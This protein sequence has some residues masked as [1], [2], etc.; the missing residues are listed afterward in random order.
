MN[1]DELLDC[2]SERDEVVGT[3]W[4]SILYTKKSTC[5][6]VVNG[7]VIN[8]A[9]KLW[10]PR[11]SVQKKLFP[12]HLDASVGGHVMSGESYEQ[13]FIRETQEELGITLQ[14]GCYTTLGYLTPHDHGTSAFMWV[15]GIY[16][17]AIPEY[18]RE[19]FIDYYW[20]S[21]D[22]FFERLAQGDKS[23]SDLPPILR[24]LKHK[25]II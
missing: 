10:I 6:R 11:R 8:A 1:N 3:E 18:N 2:V 20:L 12:L 21:I 23:K 7:F 24:A 17:D 16:Q 14:P 13:A 22:E 9:G 4:R 25:M 5:F 19:D 15:Y